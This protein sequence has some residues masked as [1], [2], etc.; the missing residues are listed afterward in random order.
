MTHNALLF[1]FDVFFLI[2]SYHTTY[3]SS[4]IEEKIHVQHT[5]EYIFQCKMCNFPVRV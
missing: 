2:I 3:V 1:C 4:F 5:P